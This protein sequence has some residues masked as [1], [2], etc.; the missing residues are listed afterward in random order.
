M[1]GRGF[2][3]TRTGAEDAV[4][5]TSQNNKSRYAVVAP[6]LGDLRKICF[7]GESGLL[8]VIAP[9]MIANYNKNLS[10]IDLVNGSTIEGFS[11]DK[12]DRLRGPQFHRAWC[13][14]ISSWRYPDAWDML[15][16]GLRLPE[17]GDPQAIITSTPRPTKLVKLIT[18]TPGT[19]ITTGSTYENE[20]N[21]APSF[22]RRVKSRYEGTR[23]GEQELL[24]KLLTELEGSLWKRDMIIHVKPSEV[25]E[26][27]RIVIAIDPAVTA[28]PDSD[29]TGIIVVGKGIDGF[30]YVLD[31]L[32]GILSVSKWPRR[33]VNA[34]YKYE[35]DM[36]VGEVNNGGDLVERAVKVD[37]PLVPFKAVR[38]SRGKIVRAEPIAQLYEKKLVRHVGVLGKLEDQMCTFDPALMD[39]SPDRVDALVWGLTELADSDETTLRIR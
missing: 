23:L 26:F 2:G 16:F 15:E 28:N 36:I 9:E 35:G 31:D 24:G 20:K 12:P 13:D 4:A 18:S 5:F 19:K 32:S 21:L 8:K 37:D 30:Y 38:A 27:V 22:L 10:I 39:D 29:E 17:F 14:E 34:Y 7:E 1:A 33:A 3:K 6:T 11:A 25:P